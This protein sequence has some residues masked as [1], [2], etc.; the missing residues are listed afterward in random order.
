[1]VVGRRSFPFGMAYFQG[2]TVSF[3]E[4]IEN[5]L[6]FSVAIFCWG[7]ANSTRC[8]KHKTSDISMRIRINMSFWYVIICSLAF[9]G[10]VLLM[11]EILHHL[12]C[13]KPYK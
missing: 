11:A 8:S 10:V 4:G 5:P 1:M 3:R 2:Q 12:G 7:V 9:C 6:T 13:M